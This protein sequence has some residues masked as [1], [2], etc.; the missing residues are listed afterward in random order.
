MIWVCP[1]GDG[2]A[3]SADEGV[4]VLNNDANEGA[5]ACS[6]SGTSRRGLRAAHVSWSR[7]TRATGGG[8]GDR[9]DSERR[10]DEELEEH[11]VERE[12]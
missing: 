8:S 6:S 3:V 7:I 2:G 11:C 1:Y 9:K 4:D 10:S 12:S 5:D